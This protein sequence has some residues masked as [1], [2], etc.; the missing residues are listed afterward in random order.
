MT[1][2]NDLTISIVI[3]AYNA[4]KYITRAIE[5]VLAQTRQPNEIIVVDD[6]ST[7]NTVEVVRSFG[8]KVILIKQE[9]SGPGIARNTGIK[10]AKSEWI[11]FLDADDELIAERLQLQ[12]EH[13]KNNPDLVWAT[14]N[15]FK[16]FCDEEHTRTIV[17]QGRSENILSGLEYYNDY[18]DSYKAGTCGNMNTM[19]IRRDVLFEAGLFRPEQIRMDDEDLWFRIAYRHPRIGY[20]TTP[21]AVYHRGVT[22]S[23]VKTHNQPEVVIELIKRHL[24]LASEMGRLDVFES[25]AR[26]ITKMWIHWSWEDERAFQIRPI[27]KELGFLLPGGYKLALY[28][29]TISPKLTLNLMPVLRKVNKVL[30]IP[31]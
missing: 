13:L 19:L 3:P 5:S 4:E 16:C 2:D 31:L 28:I 12:T 6:G 18:F 21:L 7:D 11:A 8:D 25:V 26:T 23:L 15:Y 10:A 22:G 14:S 9:N 30:K 1:Y 29:L 27:L 17:D 20:L 24:V